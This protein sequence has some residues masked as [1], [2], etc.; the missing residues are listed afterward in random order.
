MPHTP[1][2]HYAMEDE[3]M[4][5]HAQVMHNQLDSDLADFTPAFPWLVAPLVAD[6]QAS[7]DAANA[8]PL[9]TQIAAQL[10]VL[11]ED[12]KTLQKEANTALR[13]LHTYALL[14]YPN[15]KKRQQVFGQEEWP[16]IQQSNEK[17]IIALEVAHSLSGTAPYN[18]ELQ[19]L[20]YTAAQNTQLLTIAN[21]LRTARQLQLDAKSLRPVITKD[22][23]ST[24]NAIWQ[25]LKNISEAA[26]VVYASNPAKLK[27]YRLYAKN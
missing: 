13:V 25:T 23:I 6:M 26:Q 9:D 16:N 24:Y 22:R 17:M 27:Q 2:R 18:A 10:K 20:G 21:N 11:T 3:A 19:A 14:T 4:L 5:V 15:D 7:I 12:V 8:L 1:I